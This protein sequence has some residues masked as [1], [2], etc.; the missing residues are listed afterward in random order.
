VAGVR[1]SVPASA[2]LVDGGSP[3][4]GEDDFVDQAAED[5][6]GFEPGVGFQQRLN[7]AIDF[8]PVELGHGGMQ[9]WGRLGPHFVS[10]ENR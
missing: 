10:P 1:S 5:F 2:P 7:E 6:G 9:E 3:G 4:W 8:L